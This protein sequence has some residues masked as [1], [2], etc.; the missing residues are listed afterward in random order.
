MP[1]L[2]TEKKASIEKISGDYDYKKMMLDVPMPIHDWI[3][4]IAERTGIT[5]P[6]VVQLVLQQAIQSPATSY[7]EQIERTNAERELES[8]EKQE[9]ELKQRRVLLTEKLR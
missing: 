7:I 1:K 5:Q 9:Q 3:R 8:L 2:Q 6:K 4:T